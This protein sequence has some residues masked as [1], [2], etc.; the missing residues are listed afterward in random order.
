MEDELALSTAGCG[1]PD[2]FLLIATTSLKE[3]VELALVS[4]AAGIIRK[5]SRW[6]ATPW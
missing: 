2:A 1:V 5:K 3:G 4:S 6:G